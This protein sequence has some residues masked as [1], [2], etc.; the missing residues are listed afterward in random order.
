MTPLIT[1]QRNKT[2]QT[3]YDIFI[4]KIGCVFFVILFCKALVPIHLVL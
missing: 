3:S 2:I 4:L 1:D